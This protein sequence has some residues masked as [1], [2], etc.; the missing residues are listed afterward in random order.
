[1]AEMSDL[2]V[3]ADVSS[4]AHGT[5]GPS[6]RRRGRRFACICGSMVALCGVAAVALVAQPGQPSELAAAAALLQPAPPVQLTSDDAAVVS[7]AVASVP[8][9]ST[10]TRTLQ[11]QGVS[12]HVDGT[13]VGVLSIASRTSGFEQSF[14]TEAAANAQRVGMSVPSAVA[15]VQQQSAQLG[16]Q[17][18]VAFE[19][20][21]QLEWQ[22]SQTDGTEVP[23]ATAQAEGQYSYNQFEASQSTGNPLPLPTGTLSAEEAFLSPEAIQNYQYSLSIRAEQAKIAGPSSYDPNGEIVSKTSVLAA[24]MGQQLGIHAVSVTGVAGVTTSS[25]PSDLP[26]VIG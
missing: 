6:S 12:V 17:S 22:A 18:A 10:L 20:L 13:S 14:I 11:G 24:W 2:S 26:A 15:T 21:N 9:L 5:G 3:N 4:A 19:V 7:S 1:M 23:L 25:L 16:L 8:S